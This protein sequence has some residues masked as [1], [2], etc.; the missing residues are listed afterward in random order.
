MT[1]IR[2]ILHPTDFSRHSQ[3]ALALA[4][5]LAREEHSRL[6]I[7]HVAPAKAG[8]DELAEAKDRLERLP[9][10]C[11]PQREERLLKQGEPTGMILTTA[12]QMA[13]DLIVMGTHGW[14]GEV[15]RLLGSVAEKVAQNARCTVV[16]ARS[17]QMAPEPEAPAEDELA[18]IL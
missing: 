4:C 12:R 14:T 16:T 8:P 7:L 11:L 10:S 17:P 15:R 3:Q 6:V 18:V 13:C 1:R 5:D 9:V 2:T